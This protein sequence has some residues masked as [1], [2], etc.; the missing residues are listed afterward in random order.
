MQIINIKP[1]TISAASENGETVLMVSILM[2]VSACTE[3]LF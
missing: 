1:S 3:E 2:E